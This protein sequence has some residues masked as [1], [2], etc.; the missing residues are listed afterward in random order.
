MPALPEVPDRI[1][2][3]QARPKSEAHFLYPTRRPE[4]DNRAPGI[5]NGAYWMNGGRTNESSN[6]MTKSI[7][8]RGLAHRAV[9]GFMCSYSTRR[10]G[11]FGGEYVS[12][13]S[14]ADRAHVRLIHAML[15]RLITVWPI[16]G[17]YKPLET[18][19]ALL[20]F[21]GSR[22]TNKLG[23]RYTYIGVGLSW[24]EPNTH[25]AACKNSQ[26]HSPPIPSTET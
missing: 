8:S 20:Q 3:N 19:I 6:N 13:P 25:W 14:P 26:V 5:L 9:D 11:P 24:W 21:H 4:A 22:P 2:L 18:R 7:L 15:F 10:R 1:M 17:V 16:I 23:A 12:R